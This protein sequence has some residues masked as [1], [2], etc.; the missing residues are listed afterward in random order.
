MVLRPLK[1]A[2]AKVGVWNIGSY[3]MVTITVYLGHKDIGHIFMRKLIWWCQ[4]DTC[5]STVRCIQYI[6]APLSGYIWKLFRG[7]LDDYKSNKWV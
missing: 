1:E 5:S 2:I 3:S 4:R 6:E 7:E